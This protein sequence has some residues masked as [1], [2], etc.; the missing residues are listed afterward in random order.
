MASDEGIITSTDALN[1][2]ETIPKHVKKISKK[3]AQDLLSRLAKDKWVV[4]VGR[5]VY[6]IF[7]VCVFL[8]L[9]FCFP[10]KVPSSI[11]KLYLSVL[12]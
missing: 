3:E 8:F 7:C 2:V 5:H 10:P 4:K 11:G 6:R 1:L 9:F 12:N